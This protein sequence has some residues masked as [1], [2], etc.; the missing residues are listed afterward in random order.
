LIGV[1]ANRRT[2]SVLIALALF[3]VL[4]PVA[5]AADCA[6]PP[7]IEQALALTEAAFVGEVTAVDFDGRVATFE[8]LEVW[9]GVLEEQVIVNGG[10]DLS[11]LTAARARGE[12]VFTSG[13]RSYRLGEV[14]LVLAQR[15]DGPILRDGGCSATQV[16]T[17]ALE[18]ARPDSA[19][20]P[21]AVVEV[22]PVD[23]VDDGGSGWA[24][25]LALAGLAAAAAAGVWL[26]VRRREDADAAIW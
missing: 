19:H 5:A 22:V 24:I 26:V 12:E 16:F 15:G 3:L 21:I 25:P 13:D 1:E 4:R 10:P 17:Q 6:P 9:K 20:A 2:Y 11:E 14:Y 23:P 8:V 7:D 18:L